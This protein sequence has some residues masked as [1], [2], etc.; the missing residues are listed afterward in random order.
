MADG[1]TVYQWVAGYEGP[2]R[3]AG[4][5]GLARLFIDGARLTS[6][7]T[8]SPSWASTPLIP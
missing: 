5:D 6:F 3:D 8:K 1:R 4:T 7:C 2:C